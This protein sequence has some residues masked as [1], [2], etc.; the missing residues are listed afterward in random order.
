MNDKSGEMAVSPA[1]VA[2]FAAE[3]SRII[4]MT[5]ARSLERTEV[6]QHGQDAERLLTIGLDFTTQAIMIAMQ[7]VNPALLDQQLQWGN[8]R[9]PH[10]GVS[11]EQLL[12]R[13]QILAEVITETLASLD[14]QAVN[15]YV[16]RLI[17]REAALVQGANR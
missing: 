16:N 7:L 6:A 4:E 15:S 17:Q 11:A 1:T 8:T 10:D 14:A 3:R 13:F 12:Q 5:V 2:V 9:L